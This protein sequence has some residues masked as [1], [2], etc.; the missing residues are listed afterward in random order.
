MFKCGRCGEDFA[1]KDST[2]RHKKRRYDCD[3]N[4]ANG[5]RNQVYK[6]TRLNRR[7]SDDSDDDGDLYSRNSTTEEEDDDIPY[8]DG[9]EFCDNK[10]KTVETLNKMMKML[11]I[12]EHRW[13][14]IASGILEEDRKK[15]I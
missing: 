14:R 12:P 5:G 15:A 1:R 11:K 8:F 9:D 4:T 6:S 10:P 7:N 3:A 13:S 2:S